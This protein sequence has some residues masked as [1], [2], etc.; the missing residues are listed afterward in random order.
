MKKAA[1]Q[2]VVGTSLRAAPHR[3]RQKCHLT[4]SKPHAERLLDMG[5]AGCGIGGQ[6][7]WAGRASPAWALK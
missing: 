5:G 7:A 6:A 4:N 1:N 2:A 3:R